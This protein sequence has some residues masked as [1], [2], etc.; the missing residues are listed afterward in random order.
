M[1]FEI[2][3]LRKSNPVIVH[4]DNIKSFQIRKTAESKLKYLLK[5]KEMPNKPTKTPE[6]DPSS[7]SKDTAETPRVRK[8]NAPKTNR[9]LCIPTSDPPRMF[10]DKVFKRRENLRR[11]FHNRHYDYDEQLIS[12]FNLCF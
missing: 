8:A 1:L 3:H 5:F 7:N 11:H 4:A 12:D 2:K 10:C 9:E 6:L